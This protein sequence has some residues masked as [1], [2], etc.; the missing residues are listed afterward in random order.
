MYVGCNSWAAALTGSASEVL[1]GALASALCQIAVVQ[2]PV[3][4]AAPLA[5][6]SRAFD[7]C[8]LTR[9]EREKEVK[10]RE[11]CGRDRRYSSC[12]A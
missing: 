5:D 9:H 12:A 8:D 7:L 6:W 4:R 1:S 2:I 10:E 3:L 11:G